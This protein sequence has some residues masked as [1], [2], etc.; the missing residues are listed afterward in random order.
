MPLFNLFVLFLF[1]ASDLFSSPST[2]LEKIF[3]NQSITF[4]QIGSHEGN[5][6]NDPIFSLVN[7]YQWKGVLIEP[8]PYLFERLKMN[9]KNVSGVFF[10]NEIISDS[11]EIV[12]FYYFDEEDVQSPGLPS[13]VSQ[14]GS[15]NSAHAGVHLPGI[16][17]KKFTKKC[18]TFQDIINKYRFN[19]VDLLHIDTEGHDVVILQS[20]NFDKIKPKVILFEH[21]HADG[22]FV[23]G[24]KYKH[25]CDYLEKNGYALI[26]KNSEDTLMIQQNF[27]RRWNP[28]RRRLVLE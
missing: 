17:V 24:E 6:I 23:V 11:N 26:Y 21:K 5:T 3:K 9:Y 28:A 27:L 10:E 19:E 18:L 13:W 2:E 1:L 7:K 14:L 22:V 25:C 8:I 12:D 20:I 16:E 15:V 4:I